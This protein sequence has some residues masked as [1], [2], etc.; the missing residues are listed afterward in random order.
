MSYLATFKRKNKTYYYLVETI[1]LGK[2]KR[3]QIRKYIGNEK[4]F[5]KRLSLL[6]SQFGQDVE[7][8]K[9]NFGGFAYLD[10]DTIKEID[11]INKQF[12]QRYNKLSKVE[13][14]QFDKNFI[15]TF[16]YNTNSIEGSTLTL[17]EV[18]L[19]LEEGIA[20]NKSVNDVYEAKNAE[21]AVEFT[22]DY[23]K[24]KEIVWK[25]VVI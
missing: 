7:K 11:I 20:P 19:L 17:K 22:K 3:K 16:V 24:A 1:S 8:E 10:S 15:M 9:V 23:F 5:G 12:W 6:M 13:R 21:K 14:E 2:G 4:P 25:D 18:E